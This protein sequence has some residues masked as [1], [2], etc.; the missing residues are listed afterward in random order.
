[1]PFGPDANPEHRRVRR[2]AVVR[3]V[4]HTYHA[5]RVV[6]LLKPSHPSI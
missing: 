1:V 3:R 4:S 5:S 6:Y 2:R